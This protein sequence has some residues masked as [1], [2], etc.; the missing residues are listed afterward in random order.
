M[1][2]AS[3]IVHAAESMRSWQSPVRIHGSNA[4]AAVAVRGAVVALASLE[5]LLDSVPD[6]KAELAAVQILQG[7]ATVGAK[8]EAQSKNS[9]QRLAETR[10][11]SNRESQM[12]SHCRQ[13]A[14]M[15]VG[16]T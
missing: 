11:Y 1:E 8:D 15:H 10:D 4:A 12:D 16:K 2:M 7:A 9:A 6:L 5:E 13:G 14:L 3:A